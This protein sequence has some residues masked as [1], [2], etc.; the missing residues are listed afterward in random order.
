MTESLGD[1]LSQSYETD[2]LH[3]A[4]QW[5]LSGMNQRDYCHS[6]GLKYSRF[7]HTRSKLAGVKTKIKHVKSSK[8]FIPLRVSPPLEAAKPVVSLNNAERMIIRFAKGSQ[9][10]FSA[11]LPIDQLSALFKALETILC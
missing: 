9:L 6:H 5:P 10:E 1:A 8:P 4:K 7:V 11:A 3:H 2:Y